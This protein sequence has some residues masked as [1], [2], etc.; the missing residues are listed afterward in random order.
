M[1]RVE[2]K[3]D[4]IDYYYNALITGPRGHCI[5]NKLDKN[6]LL[7]LILYESIPRLIWINSYFQY[8]IITA[9]QFSLFFSQNIKNRIKTQILKY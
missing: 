5:R 1:A 6:I 9:T 8:E 4:R 2:A 7:N 3:R